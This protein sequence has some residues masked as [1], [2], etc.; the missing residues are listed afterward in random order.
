VVMDSLDS[1]LTQARDA[2]ESNSGQLRMMIANGDEVAPA[3][4]KLP[5]GLTWA[6]ECVTPDPKVAASVSAL[7]CG[8]VVANDLDAAQRG[9]AI[10]TVD[11]AVT[12][13]GTMVTRSGV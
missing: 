1:A 4:Q 2:Q 7:L 5:E 11:V 8:T 13:S 3:K 6:R 12:L 10:D 9:I